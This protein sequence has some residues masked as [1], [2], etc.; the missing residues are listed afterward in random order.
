[1]TATHPT[2]KASRFWLPELDIL[3]FFAFFWVFTFHGPLSHPEYY[4]DLGL[5]LKTATVISAFFQGWGVDVF[6][7]LSA[8]LITELL[9]REYQQHGHIH[10]RAFLA[11]RALRIWP[12]YFFLV[13][14]VYLV[15]PW[16]IEVGPF[17]LTSFIAYCTFWF[18]WWIASG[19]EARNYMVGNLI[20]PLWSI[21]V[22]EQFYI[23][24]P[25]LFAWTRARKSRFLLISG[26]LLAM[27]WL[28]RII[29]TLNQVERVD[30]WWFNSFVRVDSIVFG[31]L[32]AM[33]L[34]GRIPRWRWPIRLLMG[35]AAV[36]AFWC[37]S[38][39]GDRNYVSGWWSYPL[40]G[41]GSLLSLLA[42]LG[43]PVPR[44]LITRTLGFL[45]KISYGLYAWHTFAYFLVGLFAPRIAPTADFAL[46]FVATVILA[47]STWHLLER[48]MLQLKQR[49]TVAPTGDPST[50]NNANKRGTPRLRV[51]ALAVFTVALAALLL[52]PRY[53][54][55][56]L[57]YGDQ[58]AFIGFR[59]RQ[60]TLSE[61]YR[62]V[63]VEVLLK[64]LQP[65]LKNYAIKIDMFDLN[66]NSLEQVTANFP[67]HA[68]QWRQGEVSP[69]STS[70]IYEPKKPAP[71][72]AKFMLSIIDP[73]TQMPLPVSC[74]AASCEPKF[75]EIHVQLSPQQ[76]ARWQAAPSQYRIAD[77]LDVLS[78][79]APNT[80]RTGE[81]LTATVAWRVNTPTPKT[82]SSFI[83]VLNDKGELVAQSQSPAL[84]TRYPTPV[85]TTNEIIIGDV[86]VALPTDLPAG[87]YTLNYGMYALDTVERQPIHTL[88]N[89]PPA[90]DDL[91]PLGILQIE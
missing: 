34:Q 25:F 11:R 41:V 69:I 88:G 13:L 81:T 58:L 60:T 18:N 8:Y 63:E 44:N 21:S 15:V 87:R 53:E 46:S 9:R 70:F 76:Q 82:L 45:G 2:E 57:R 54:Q 20:I 16:V 49:F 31:A 47:T 42:A 66:G 72:I 67:T 29:L 86:T 84:T 73:D 24:W 6:F 55:A 85:W 48:P 17:D 19:H 80:L 36:G 77:A 33:L 59:V 79:T 68:D 56:N 35:T 90:K 10:V 32:T 83:H 23:A 14:F 91:I 65:T 78:V 22:E 30:T 89:A 50:L 40:S 5:S 4:V 43:T 39:L 62:P 64:A 52:K 71:Y 51:L 38:Y 75:G 37:S 61:T 28:T 7:C 12:L 3:R 1:M 74:D 27:A 26:V